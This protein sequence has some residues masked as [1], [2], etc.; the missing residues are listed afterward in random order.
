MQVIL[1]PDYLALAQEPKQVSEPG[2]LYASDIDLDHVS[3]DAPLH[4]EMTC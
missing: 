1:S 2:K 3:H 4:P